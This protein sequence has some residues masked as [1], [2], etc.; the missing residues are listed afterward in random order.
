MKLNPIFKNGKS[1][2]LPY[3]HG[4]EH[5]PTDFNLVNV[6]PQYVI[7]LAIKGKFNAFVCQAGI[8]HHYIEHHKKTVPLVIKLNA[9]GKIPKIEPISVQNCS[10]KR[11][12]KL[13]ADAVGYTIYLGSEHEREMFK[14]FGK[15][16][17]EAHDYS[18]P[19]I[20]WVYPRGR[21]VK[22]DLTTDILAYAAR[23]GLELGADVVKVKYNNDKE[24]YKWV[25]QNAGKAKLIV[26][27]GPGIELGEKYLRHVRDFMDA[28]ASGMAIGRN[29]WQSE[30]PLKITKALKSLIFDNAKVKDALK[31]LK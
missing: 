11:A 1:L 12:V 23:T 19:V 27:G 8:A 3:D 21:F 31:W 26:S 13:Q 30:K 28:G 16:V 7:D 4:I 5:S 10:V 9:K 25:V 6:D 14:E 2:I 29:I 15:I 20:V 24:G 17:E 22:D 18:L